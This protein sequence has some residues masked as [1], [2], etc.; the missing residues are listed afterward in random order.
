MKAENWLKKQIVPGVTIEEL[1]K[2]AEQ[3]V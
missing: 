2:K 3:T 1:K